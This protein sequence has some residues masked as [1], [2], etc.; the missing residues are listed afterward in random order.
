MKSFTFSTGAVLRA[1]ALNVR[2]RLA[3]LGGTEQQP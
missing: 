3:P 2:R 1:R